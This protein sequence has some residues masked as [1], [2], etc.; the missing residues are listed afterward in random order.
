MLMP[1]VLVAASLKPSGSMVPGARR[2][3]GGCRTAG[4][5]GDSA[6]SPCKMKRR[7]GSGAS[8]D[9]S[10]VHGKSDGRHATDSLGASA[11][12]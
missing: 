1:W 3:M 4:V 7:P 12:G 5:I 10:I 11:H 6:Q 2:S 9:W 8:S